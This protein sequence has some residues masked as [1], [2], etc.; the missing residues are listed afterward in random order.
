[1]PEKKEKVYHCTEPTCS[2][3][4]RGEAGSFTGGISP[5]GL[6]VLTGEPVEN[7]TKENEGKTW[8]EGVCPNC[9]SKGKV[10]A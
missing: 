1:M 7:C 8:G 6:N 5:E 4:A 2:L 3:G 10:A 9:G